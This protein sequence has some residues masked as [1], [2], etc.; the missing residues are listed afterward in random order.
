MVE[1]INRYWFQ[2]CMMNILTRLWIHI[3]DNT[4]WVLS[5]RPQE[6]ALCIRIA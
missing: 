3:H 2:G 4:L 1:K 6:L 5:L